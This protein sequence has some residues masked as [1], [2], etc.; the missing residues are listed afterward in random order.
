MKKYIALIFTLFFGVCFLASGQNNL[1]KSD[2]AGRIAL[3]IFI[4]DQAEATPDIAASLLRDRIS[5]ML[6]NYSLSGSDEGGRFIVVP[7]VSVLG[8]EVTA[9]VPA[10][11]VISLQT[12]LYIG[13]GYQGIKFSTTSLMSKGVGQNE[14]KAYID[15]IRKMKVNDLSIQSFIENGKKKIIE[16]YNSICDFNIKKANTLAGQNNFDEAMYLLTSVPE[17]AKACYD[18]SMDAVSPIF[19]KAIDFRCSQSLAK[20]KS[21]WSASQDLVAANLVAEELANIDPNASCVG[22]VNQFIAVVNKRVLDLD[23]R[24]WNFML[25]QQQDA[26]DTRKAEI[27]AA[28]DIGVAYGNNQPKTVYNT[29]VIRTWW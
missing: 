24:G 4:P 18:K 10:M 11:T 2:D 28:R 1:G 16:Y 29:A 23:K 12:S 8:K 3:N 5:Q 20:A 19:K 17:V 7:V 13:D 15:A 21:I 26:V 22:E 6:T 27:R 9:T 25:K 14:T